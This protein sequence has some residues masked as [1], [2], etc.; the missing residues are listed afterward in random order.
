MALWRRYSKQEFPGH[1]D[2]IACTVGG[3]RGV[4]IFNVPL[5]GYLQYVAQAFGQTST[6]VLTA[7]CTSC[8]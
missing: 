7:D 5:S 3:Q 8:G 4:F 1:C 6:V 2:H